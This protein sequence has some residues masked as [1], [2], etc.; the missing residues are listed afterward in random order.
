MEQETEQKK[1]L[2]RIRRIEGQV[3]AIRNMME[4]GDDFRDV[5]VQIRAVQSALRALRIEGSLL[6]FPSLSAQE[7]GKLRSLL[8]RFC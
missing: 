3:R 8:K 2:N 7:R 1:I 6:S 4:R 5:E